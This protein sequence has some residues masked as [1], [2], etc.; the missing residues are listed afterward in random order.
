MYRKF[1]ASTN[2][3]LATTPF[4]PLWVNDAIWWHGSWSKLAQVIDCC[5]TIPSHYLKSKVSF[6]I[7]LKVTSQEVL[8]NLIRNMCSEIIL[9]THWGRVTH[10]RVAYLTT[11]ASGN[12]LSPSRR[13]A[14]IWTNAG[15]L[16]IRPLGT[17]FSEILIE[18]H[19]FS[20]KKMHLKMSSAK[21]RPFWLGLNVLKSLPH[22]SG[23]KELY[24]YAS[25]FNLRVLLTGYFDKN[26]GRFCPRVIFIHTIIG[27]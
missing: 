3:G 15:M 20:F 12:G 8:M 25:N 1:Y 26:K 14:I 6:G 5:L 18:I 22:L 11:I 2:Y 19:T 13:Q 17:N 10:I 7:R 23:A 4:N 24:R 27:W 9:L 21:R 16:L